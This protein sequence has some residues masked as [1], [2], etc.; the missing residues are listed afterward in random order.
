MP[1][2][3]KPTDETAG[4]D[5]EQSV[6]P[7]SADQHAPSSGGDTESAATE[8]ESPDADTTKT[9]ENE[10][11][12]AANG[13]PETKPDALPWTSGWQH[14]PVTPPPS[15]RAEPSGATAFPDYP[16]RQP[17]PVAPPRWRRVTCPR[18][19]LPSACVVGVTAAVTIPL[20]RPGIG[21]LLAGSTAAGAVALVDYR[22]RRALPT[23]PVAPVDAA[24]VDAAEGT[25][26][27]S[28]VDTQESSPKENT[29]D[30]DPTRGRWTRVVSYR[31][32]AQGSGA[33]AASAAARPGTPTPRAWVSRGAGADAASSPGRSRH[34]ERIWWSAAALALL[35][36]G[37]VR[38]AEWLFILCAVAACLAG[39]LAVVGRR[40]ANSVIYD[41]FAVP[42]AALE[43]VPWVYA[44]TTRMRSAAGSR[45]WRLGISAGVTVF[46]LAIF[47]PLLGSAD[48]TFASLLDGLTPRPE[49]GSI[50]R[51]IMLFVL[52][53]M[54]SLGAMYLLAGPP[55]PASR[56]LHPISSR[57]F[58][59][60]WVLPVG[61]LTA[62]F[63][64]FIGAQLVA[65]FGGDDYVQRT[66]GLT[67]AEYARSGFWQLSVV[68]ILTLLVI[69]TV[70]RWARQDS[71]VER[72]WLRLLLTAISGLTLVILASALGR[73]WTY[74][75]AYGFTVLRLLVEACELWL[76]VVYLLVIVAVLRLERIW[77]PRAAIGTAL[78]TLLALAVLNPEG[79]IADRNI[80]RW[81][82]GK[83]LDLNYLSTLS[84]D[85]VPATH[86]LPDSARDRLIADLREKM[87]DDTWNSWNLSRATAR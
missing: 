49:A 50:F 9:A 2:T 14:K 62:L 52:A 40:S 43:A 65:L 21:W 20:D 54:G 56:G 53:A 85:I 17:M 48:A 26:S 46:L 77:L 30:N 29:A 24:E 47:I 45:Q 71:A 57:S 7:P 60:E 74:Q 16:L 83:A 35:A 70:L 8:A 59:L 79:L 64:A 19:V 31:S 82:R 80:D 3:P 68:T 81:E 25:A 33:A 6:T 41:V 23:Q 4:D 76:G 51:W 37:A 38:A 27:T 22:A 69:L 75:Q 61:A 73:M 5:R 67:Y 13:A 12:S 66:A 28:A 34:W 39:S 78:A 15:A 86:R 10:P 42:L 87:D 18:G 1:D 63:A 84:P 72:L 36:V 58:G 32:A 55:M 11:D 44:A